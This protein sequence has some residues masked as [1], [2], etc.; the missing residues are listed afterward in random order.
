MTLRLDAELHT[1]LR[2]TADSMDVPMTDIIEAALR[3]ILPE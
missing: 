2:R 1:L 3:K